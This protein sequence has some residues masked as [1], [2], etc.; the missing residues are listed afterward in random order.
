M[1]QNRQVC[2]YPPFLSFIPKP[3]R[4]WH[5]CPNEYT[6]SPPA[7]TDFSS[8]LCMSPLTLL[9]LAA[10]TLTTSAFLPQVWKTWR[11]RSAGD[12]SL[13]MYGTLTTGVGLWLVYGVLVGDPAIIVANGI[14]FPLALSVLVMALRYRRHEMAAE[15]EAD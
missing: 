11:S 6:L 9:G 4:M 14:T 5:Y 8:S 3:D 15:V 12:L 1:C 7:L 10:A 2:A 13:G